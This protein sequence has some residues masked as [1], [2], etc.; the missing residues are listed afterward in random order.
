MRAKGRQCAA[1]CILLAAAL[2][3]MAAP[4]LMAQ[5][6]GGGPPPG[7]GQGPGGPPGGAGAPGGG[8]GGNLGGIPAGPQG[9]GGLPGQ[10]P[11]AAGQGA[12]RARGG[13][14]IGPPGRWW[15]DNSYAKALKLRPE[16]QARMDAIFEQNRTTLTS[17]Y[18]ELR[19]AENQMERLSNAPTLDEAALFVQIDRVKQARAELDKVYTHM[20]LQIR[21][22]MD[23]DQIARL[24]KR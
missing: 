8:L 20:L 15:D 7:G 9:R 5:G 18:D 2:L 12:G 19:Q 13:V 3:A 6:R 10:L 21:K 17:H 14:A 11:S 22:E 4:K 24:E 1:L 23:P 16:Q